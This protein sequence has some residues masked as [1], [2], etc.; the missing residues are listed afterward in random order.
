MIP[1]PMDL[2]THILRGDWPPLISA[3]RESSYVNGEVFGVHGGKVP[4]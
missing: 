2:R 1:R 4:S 3:T